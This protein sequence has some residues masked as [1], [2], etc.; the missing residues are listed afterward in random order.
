MIQAYQEQIFWHYILENQI[1]LN[2]TRPEFFTNQTLR[3]MFEIAKDHA[4]RYSSPPSKDQM[5]ELIRVKGV[6]ET[7][8]PDIVNALYNAKEQLAPMVRG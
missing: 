2:T 3:D 5:S 8:S 4:L 7:I 6:A 1:Y